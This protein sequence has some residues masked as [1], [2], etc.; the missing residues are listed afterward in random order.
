M[1]SCPLSPH[2]STIHGP[3]NS[4][5]PLLLPLRSLFSFLSL[6]AIM[7]ASSSG[8]Y[9]PFLYIHICICVC[10]YTIKLELL[11]FQFFFHFQFEL[12]D[13]FN[14]GFGFDLDVDFDF[15]Q[16]LG[17]GGGN[18]SEESSPE[19]LDRNPSTSTM[20]TM[21]IM[22][23]K[24]MSTSINRTNIPN[25]TMTTVIHPILQLPPEQ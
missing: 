9:T 4:S 21:R 18:G 17:T 23:K 12:W 10:I 22:K 7:P 3:H 11:R 2:T 13:N 8:T 25:L 6:A 5:K 19:N 14:F 20:M 15:L 24:T 16:R 1:F